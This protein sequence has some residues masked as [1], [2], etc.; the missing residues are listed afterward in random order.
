MSFDGFYNLQPP[1]VQLR[2]ISYRPA[3]FHHH[4][5]GKGNSSPACRINLRHHIACILL[6]A[7]GEDLQVVTHLH[8]VHTALYAGFLH[9]LKVQQGHR[10]LAVGKHHLL[11]ENI[12]VHPLQIVQLKALDLNLLHQLFVIG[13]YGI[14]GIDQIVPDF[15]GC[16]IM[17][18]KQRLELSHCLHGLGCA[19]PH[20]LGLIQYHNRTA[21]GNNINRPK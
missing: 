10:R 13:I 21:V 8:L 17:Q 12:A 1:L 16:R 3:A 6:H 4:P 18:E 14:K 7:V 2:N 19:A 20:L 9:N 15:V 5:I 11:Q